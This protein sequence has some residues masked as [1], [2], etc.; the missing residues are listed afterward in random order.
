MWLLNTQS[1]QLREFISDDGIPPYAILSH[2]WGGEE[3]T[4]QQWQ[5]PD[6]A[7][8]RHMKGYQK[9]LRFAQQATAASFEWAWVDTYAQPAT[10]PSLS[11][12]CAQADAV[13]LL[14]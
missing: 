8:I 9:V 6:H 2:T 1:L 14:H 12:L 7:A 5:S 3:V 4:Y 11:L 10:R 13:K